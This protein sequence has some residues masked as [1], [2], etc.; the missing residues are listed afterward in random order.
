M[1]VGYANS[2]TVYIRVRDEAEG[3]RVSL[4]KFCEAEG[5]E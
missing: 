4:K 5:I 2:R 3:R 1:E